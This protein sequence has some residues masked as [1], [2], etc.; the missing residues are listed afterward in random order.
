M[1]KCGRARQATD[2]NIIRRM[3]FAFWMAK[4]TDTHSEYVIHTAFPRQQWLRERA[5]VL[6]YMYIAC[7][8]NTFPASPR[9]L[10]YYLPIRFYINI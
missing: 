9:Y 6:R 7:L 4:A 1:E 8:V 10:K 2:D 3:R 5:S